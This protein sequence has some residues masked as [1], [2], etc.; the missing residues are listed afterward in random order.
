[1]SEVMA[2]RELQFS[3]GFGQRE[4]YLLAY[5]LSLKLDKNKDKKKNFFR[6]PAFS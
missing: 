2:W 3:A 6:S 1:M 4:G 5:N